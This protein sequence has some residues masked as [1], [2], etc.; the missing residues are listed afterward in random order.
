MERRYGVWDLGKLLPLPPIS[1]HPY[2]I[3]RL[4][5][6]VVVVVSKSVIS[7]PSV[8]EKS[9]STL[10]LLFVAGLFAI[11]TRRHFCV[12]AEKPVQAGRFAEACHL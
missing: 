8:V 10:P 11:F 4:L 2:H 5:F 9:R 7:V 6:A 12:F 1:R 3:G